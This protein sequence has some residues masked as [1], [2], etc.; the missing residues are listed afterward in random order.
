MRIDY[1]DVDPVFEGRTTTMGHVEGEDIMPGRG[2]GGGG[3]GGAGRGRSMG[4]GG[5]AGGAGPGGPANRPLPPNLPAGQP[6]QQGTSATDAIS[7]T[8]ATLPPNQLLDILGQMKVRHAR[9]DYTASC[10]SR[11]SR[12][13]CHPLSGTRR[14]RPRAGKNAPER[15]STAFLCSLSGNA[16]DERRRPEHP[17]GE[18]QRQ[19]TPCCVTTS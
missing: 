15:A 11:V 14:Y 13:R 1:A 18:P 10:F 3:G 17:S 12:F 7:Q 5:F 4:R 8:L 6:L 16:D 19:S 9:G 2:P